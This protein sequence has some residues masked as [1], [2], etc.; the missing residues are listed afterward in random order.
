MSDAVTIEKIRRIVEGAR[1]KPWRSV[2][3]IVEPLFAHIA[4]CPVHV[5]PRATVAMFATCA[6]L[7]IELAD[8]LASQAEDEGDLETLGAIDGRVRAIHERAQVAIARAA[9]HLN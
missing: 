4:I 5:A 1:S 3:A 7:L 2:W 8:G 9:S 6:L